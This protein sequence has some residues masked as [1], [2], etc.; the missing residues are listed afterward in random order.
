[1]PTADISEML[2]AIVSQLD[3]TQWLSLDELAG[4]QQEQMEKLVSW[5]RRWTPFFAGRGSDNQILTREEIQ[6]AGESFYATNIP[7]D[8]VGTFLTETSG[9]TGKSVRIKKTG[10]NQAFFYAYA[11]REIQWHR[12][13]LEYRLTSVRPQ[14]DH[15]RISPTWW[16]PISTLYPTGEAQSIPNTLDVKEQLKLA[17]S[18]DPEIL[19]IYPSNLAAWLDIWE[20]LDFNLRGLK[21]ISTVGERVKDELRARVWRI[22]GLGIEDCYS[23]A[24]I[25]SIA[26]QCPESG[27][28]H[29]LDETLIVEVVREDGRPCHVGETGRVIVTDLVNF[30][31][32][33]IRY[34]IGDHAEV[35]P[36]CSC[37]RGLSTLRKIIGR[38]RQML[39][40]ADG[41][42]NWPFIGYHQFSR[43]APVRQFQMIQ[44]GIRDIELKIVTDAPLTHDQEDGIRAISTRCLNGDFDVVIN[45]YRKPLPS[46][47]G[48]FEEFIRGF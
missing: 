27:L 22:C 44:H 38:E 14:N 30:A 25:G 33:V 26:H 21:H 39:L 43:V 6:N 4:L 28:Y 9:S 41:R 2:K 45:Q 7:A 11:I 34:D 35:G 1:M 10:L 17:A 3:R 40:H 31:S 36:R 23:S 37:G 48:K 13:S 32:P 18:F 15:H 16:K 19:I 20:D 29:T 5:H 24:E 47:N 8:H 12:R 46:V 42:R